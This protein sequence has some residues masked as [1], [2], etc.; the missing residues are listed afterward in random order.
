MHL[1]GSVDVETYKSKTNEYKNRQREIM[2]EMENQVEL[3]EMNMVTAQKVLRLAKLS[4]EILKV[5]IWMKTATFEIC[6]FELE[7]GW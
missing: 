7:V 1:D 5:R 6:L 4:R 3:D 2:A